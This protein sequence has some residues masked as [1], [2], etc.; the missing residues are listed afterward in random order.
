MASTRVQKK[1]ELW[2]VNSWL[3]DIF[4]EQFAETR[5]QMQNREYFEFDAANQ[6]LSIVGN[7][8]TAT[9]FTYKGKVASGK[10]SKIRADCLMLSL[11][12]AQKKLLI[13]TEHCMH[14]FSLAEQSAGRLPLD[15]DIL[16]VELPTD[17]KKE[18]IEAREIASREVRGVT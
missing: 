9:A 11:V 8:S 5:I 2:I 10:K 13:L 6:D 18:L 4:K 17:L 3:P 16:R 12:S 15:I 14:E 1:C 7:I